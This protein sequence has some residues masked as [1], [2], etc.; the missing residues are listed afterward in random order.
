MGMEKDLLPGE[1]LVVCLRPFI[2][3]LASSNLS[4]K[5]NT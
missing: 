4:P 2:E 1:E 5:T 3:H